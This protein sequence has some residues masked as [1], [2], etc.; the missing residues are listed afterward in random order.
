DV[1]SKISPTVAVDADEFFTTMAAIGDGATR[2]AFCRTLRSVSDV[3]GQTGTMLDRCYLPETIPTLMLWEARD[4]ELPVRHA[5]S[6][7]DAMPKAK[8]HSF[9][10]AGHFPHHTDPAGFLDVVTEF[11]ESTVP[12]RHDEH[13]W[14]DR[15]RT[16]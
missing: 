5:H 12:A 7:I 13:A 4:G 16:G 14:R 3:G 8:L 2:S 1:L 10:E 11:I 15:L 9:A 6:P